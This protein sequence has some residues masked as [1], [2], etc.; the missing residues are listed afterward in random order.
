T[1]AD[2]MG[3]YLQVY[4]LK[5][6]DK[7]H[8]S[9]ANFTF[10]IKQGNV[11]VPNMQFQVSSDELKQSGDQVTIERLLPLATMAPGKYSIEVVA[12]DKLSNQTVTR[13]ADFTVKAPQENKTAANTVPGR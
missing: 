8:K 11:A 1:N 9:S 13:T 6:D 7:T 2:K 12:T 5:P 4:N 3:I 10:T